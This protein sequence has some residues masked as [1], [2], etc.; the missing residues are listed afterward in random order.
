MSLISLFDILLFALFICERNNMG[1]DGT[2]ND[3]AKLCHG[4]DID[5]QVLIIEIR[6]SENPSAACHCNLQPV[7]HYA[8]ADDG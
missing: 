3:K 1:G 7:I 8:G 5:S 2:R 6:L 4:C